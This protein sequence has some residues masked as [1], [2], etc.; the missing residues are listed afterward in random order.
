[1]GSDLPTVRRHWQQLV[2]QT[3]PDHFAEDPVEQRRAT[4]RLRRLNAAFE[5]L[6]AYLES[7]SG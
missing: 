3:H 7:E 1:V 6:G 4:D 2:R 5:R